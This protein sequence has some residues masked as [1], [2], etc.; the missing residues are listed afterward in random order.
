M[1]VSITVTGR[2]SP[3]VVW[4]RYA[5]PQAWATWAPQIRRVETE[6]HGSTPLRA[7]L[8]GTV[9]AVLG[10]P[11]RFTVTEVDAASGAWSW[12]VRPPGVRL[13]LHHTVAPTSDGGTRAGLVIEGRAPVVLAY[14]V[15]A[16]IALRR[17]VSP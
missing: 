13:R 2:A 12:V 15:V 5:D 6:G 8:R 10:V 3:R 7:G 16:Q 1:Q 11:V 14:R 9:T 4:A 17:L